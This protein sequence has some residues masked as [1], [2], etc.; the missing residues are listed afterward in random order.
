M[1]DDLSE[2]PEPETA[3]GADYTH[4]ACPYCGC[5]NTDDEGDIRGEVVE[6]ADCQEKVQVT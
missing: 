5:E 2:T 6:C 4:W 1:T 3:P